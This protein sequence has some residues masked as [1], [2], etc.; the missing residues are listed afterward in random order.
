MK[1]TLHIL[2]IALLVALAYAAAPQKAVI[3]SY[4]KDTPDSVVDKAKAAIKEA[5]DRFS[6]LTQNA[7]AIQGGVIT[8]EYNIIKAFAA[9]APSKVLESVKAW[10]TEYNALVEEDQMVQTNGATH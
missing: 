10:G 9:T 4:P 2:L 7:H 3:I 1:F 8:H 5:T 6:K